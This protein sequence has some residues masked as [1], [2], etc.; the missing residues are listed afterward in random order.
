MRRLTRLKN[1]NY[2]ANGNMTSGGGAT[3]TYDVANRLVS[4]AETVEWTEY[5]GYAP[6]NKRVFRQLANGTQQITFYGARGEKLSGAEGML[7]WF[8]GKLIAD[9]VLPNNITPVYQDRSVDQSGER[10]EQSV[11][12]NGARYYPFG[13]EITGDRQ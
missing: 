2:D 1:A 7:V 13:D 5:Y 9:G 8:G 4:A 3:L 12:N 11:T 6:D 10:D